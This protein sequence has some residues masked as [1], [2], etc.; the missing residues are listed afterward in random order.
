VVTGHSRGDELVGPLVDDRVGLTRSALSANH[1]VVGVAVAVDRLE[2]G[3]VDVVARV[4]A[5]DVFLMGYS[6]T[7]VSRCQESIE[8]FW[9]A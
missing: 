5:H 1:A 9:A 6:S 2:G 3:G 4:D 7:S 8:C